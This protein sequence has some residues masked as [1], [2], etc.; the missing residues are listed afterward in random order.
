MNGKLNNINLI[1]IGNKNSCNNDVASA[2]LWLI[3]AWDTEIENM[4]YIAYCEFTLTDI[5]LYPLMHKPQCALHSTLVL[6]RDKEY[7][8]IAQPCS[9]FLLCFVP[10]HSSPPL[11]VW[12]GVTLSTSQFCLAGELAAYVCVS[13]ARPESDG[14]ARPE[15]VHPSVGKNS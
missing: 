15:S 1:V 4:V 5:I 6:I 8:K 7:N 9:V 14:G 2:P 11:T 10:Q 12:H 3:C 13:P